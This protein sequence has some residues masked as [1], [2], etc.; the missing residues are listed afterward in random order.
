MALLAVLVALALGRASSRLH[1][2]LKGKLGLVSV[3]RPY[4]WG[5]SPK[6]RYDAQVAR[7]ITVRDLSDI[8]RRRAAFTRSVWGMPSLPES[9]PLVQA[10]FRD[11]RFAALSNLR[12][13]DR[14]IVTMPY[15]L[16]SIS[17]AFLPEHWN[18]HLVLWHSGHEEDFL[19]DQDVIQFFLA[20]GYAVAAF[21]LPLYGLNS[22]PAL[23]VRE[24]LH[25]LPTHSQLECLPHPG[26]FWMTPI[27]RVVN[28]LQRSLDPRSISLIGFS[29]GGTTALGY[30]IL[31]PR[32]DETY[33]VAG[34]QP[35]IWVRHVLDQGRAPGVGPQCGE[36]LDFEGQRSLYLIANPLDQLLMAAGRGRL[37]LVKNEFDPV[38]APGR[39]FMLYE[40]VVS[41]R[42][43]R[44]GGSFGVILDTKNREHSLSPWA[45][46]RIYA[47]MRRHDP[48][49]NAG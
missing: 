1:L 31:D 45:L 4:G 46:R 5:Y 41:E 8:A 16:T 30:S 32:I 17:Y 18:H 37:V 25:P 24:V 35:S 15:G 2:G 9:L 22:R 6:G 14:F 33:V 38:I 28:Y 39:G 26:R 7:M 43:A 23:V 34:T 27:A 19:Q 36:D 42:A 11:S 48:S 12:S 20:R 10:N 40:G 29:G 44:L 49:P 47:D 21:D 3:Q 13:I